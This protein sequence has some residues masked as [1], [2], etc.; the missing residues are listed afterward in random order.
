MVLLGLVERPGRRDLSLDRLLLE[1]RLHHSL[2]GLSEAALL[3]VMIKDRSSILVAVIAELPVLRQWI[4]VVPEHVQELLIADLRGVVDDLDRLGMTCP[5]ARDLFIT[6]IGGSAA[7]IA[8]GCADHTRDLIEVGLHA[9][10]ASA[11]KSSDRGFRRLVLLRCRAY[12]QEHGDD[13]PKQTT[14]PGTPHQ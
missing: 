1:A 12:G 7:G 3:V 4:D 5:P 10:E 6:W 2:R 14:E 11:G 13:G 9:P 8:G